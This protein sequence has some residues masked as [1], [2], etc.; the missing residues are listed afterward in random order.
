MSYVLEWACSECGTLYT[1]EEDAET[2]EASHGEEEEPE[3]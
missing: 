2:C 3:R 1:L